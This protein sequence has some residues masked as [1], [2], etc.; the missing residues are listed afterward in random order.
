MRPLCRW[1]GRPI[2]KRTID[3]WFGRNPDHYPQEDDKRRT[4]REKPTALAEAQRLIGNMKITSVRWHRVRKE[5]A[6]YLD[7]GII[8]VDP[9]EFDYIDRATAW[10]GESYLP[11][12]HYFCSASCAAE[13]GQAATRHPHNVIGTAYDVAR[14]KEKGNA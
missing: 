12:Y 4:F 9:N 11:R 8:A 13:L 7:G 2:R 5:D 6:E 3:Y 1:C 10:D 14:K